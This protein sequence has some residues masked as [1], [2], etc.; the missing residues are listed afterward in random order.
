[1]LNACKRLRNRPMFGGISQCN[2]GKSEE[3]EE[4]VFIVYCEFEL[5]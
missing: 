1:M 4:S 5:K 3:A 2:G